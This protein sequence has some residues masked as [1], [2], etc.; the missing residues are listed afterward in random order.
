MVTKQFTLNNFEDFASEL[1]KQIARIEQKVADQPLNSDV[2]QHLL[3][4][5]EAAAFLHLS[6]Q[7][8]YRKVS[9]GEI[10]H[11]KR[12]KRLYFSKENLIDYVSAG[13]VL[14]NEQLISATADLLTNSK[15]N[16]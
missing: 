7:T 10:P 15:N 11:M 6:K 1:F 8:L 13:S 14:T 4:I 16:R 3:T 9:K 12:S 5:E 2:A